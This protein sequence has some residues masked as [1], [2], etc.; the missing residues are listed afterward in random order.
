MSGTA[1]IP[2]THPPSAPATWGSPPTP[3]LP[4][5]YRERFSSRPLPPALGQ[6]QVASTL[7]TTTIS[8]VADLESLWARQSTPP[9]DHLLRLL[10]ELVQDAPPPGHFVVLPADVCRARWLELPFRTRTRNCLQRASR[11]DAL[12]PGEAITVAQLL[13]LPNLGTLSLIDLMCVTEAALKSGYL[14]QGAFSDT[15]AR[16]SSDRRPSPDEPSEPLSSTTAVARPLTAGESPAVPN[17]HWDA[18]TP[19]LKRLL[20][21]AAEFRGA[22]TLGAALSIDLVDLAAAL[23]ITSDLD[24][25]LIDD[26]TDGQALADEAVVA[27]AEFWESLS[28]K[29]R[30]VLN[31]RLLTAEPLTLD[32]LGRMV[33]VTRERMRQV[34]KRLESTIRHPSSIGAQAL[35]RANTIV[36]LLRPAI[37][38]VVTESNLE[39]V[40]SSIIP[41]PSRSDRSGAAID[42]TRRM[43]R[44]ELNYSCTDGICLSVEAVEVRTDLLNAADDLADGVGI[45]KERDLLDRLPDE[46][47]L[48]YW[49]VLFDNLK[50]HRL[51]GHLALR[52]T[53]KAK[54]K[55][56]LLEIGCPATKE[57]V[58]ELS[59]LDR[60]QVGRQLSLLEGVVRADKVR[61]GMAEW[62]EDEYEGI[63]EEIIQ[64]I[65]EDDGAT[66]L[67]RLL[68]ELPEM[69]GVSENSVRSFVGT[70]QF[71][72]KDGYVSLAD[73][74]S[75]VLRPLADVIDGRNLDGTPYWCFKVEDRYF[76]GYSLAGVPPEIVK[77]FG[78]EPN[79]RTT[80][81]ISSPAGCRPLSVSWPLASVSGASLGYL[82]EPL[83]RL[84]T[85]A[86]DRVRLVIEDSGL[87]SFQRD[88]PAD[89]GGIWHGIDDP[90][91]DAD[92]HGTPSAQ[93][94]QEL[95]E[96]I[97]NRHRGL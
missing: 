69:F 82:S 85:Q 78:C 11:G 83:R 46:S 75:I 51:C 95:L 35:R 86:G 47:W 73:T 68:Q 26:I 12:P 88:R 10:V 63:A 89:S 19:L 72:L 29:E 3:I 65:H 97:K 70:P 79:G 17:A 60:N 4:K 27:V 92:P 77:T 55:A 76:D 48:E 34:Q 13:V 18:A 54:V 49:D 28:E 30:L 25:M 9:E 87:V 40:I 45:L 61:W 74:S 33:G 22:R 58:A 31:H 21:A 90:A 53:D 71:L 93:R 57:E 36:T 44:E 56:A 64:R 38:P 59:G 42:L 39:K 20:T 84:G 15:S 41:T 66:R 5:W 81:E 94:S 50:L 52:D 8:T 37:S 24:D 32:E 96:R 16:P 23:G 91:V 67:S 1:A 80:V 7:S 6:L 43:I 2:P 62:V 14:P